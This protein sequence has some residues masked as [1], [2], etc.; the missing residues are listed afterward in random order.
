MA[1]G[2]HLYRLISSG[3]QSAAKK[4]RQKASIWGHHVKSASFCVMVSEYIA[5]E[6]SK[7]PATREKMGRKG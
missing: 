6:E 5:E 1:Q 7:S 3:E 2:G 4:K